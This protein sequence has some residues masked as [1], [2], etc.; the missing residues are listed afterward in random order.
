M[1]F[2]GFFLNENN[3]CTYWMGVDRDLFF[4]LKLPCKTS[5]LMNNKLLFQQVINLHVSLSQ[6]QQAHHNIIIKPH[7]DIYF[8]LPSNQTVKKSPH[9]NSLYDFKSKFFKFIIS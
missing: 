5:I 2:S 4:S 3:I 1:F 7:E 9:I 6:V 8:S